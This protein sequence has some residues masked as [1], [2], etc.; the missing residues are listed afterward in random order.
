MTAKPKTC[1]KPIMPGWEGYRPPHPTEPISEFKRKNDYPFSTTRS[2]SKP[3]YTKI[4]ASKRTGS[5]RF[6]RPLEL[7]KITTVLET[8]L[9]SRYED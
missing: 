5:Y 1:K 7:R 4:S 8:F 2:G 3:I 6:F 9:S